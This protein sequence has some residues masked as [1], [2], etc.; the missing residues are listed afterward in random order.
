[1][2]S[3]DLQGCHWGLLPYDKSGLKRELD[4][5][6]ESIFK[7]SLKLTAPFCTSTF[8]FGCGC[9]HSKVDNTWSLRMFKWKW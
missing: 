2:Q 8:V 1:M 9:K 6:N 4:E 5:P 3:Q 7:F